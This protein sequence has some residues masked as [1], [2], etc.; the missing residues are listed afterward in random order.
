MVLDQLK[1]A[2][3]YDVLH[4]AFAEAFAFLRRPDLPDLADGRHEIDGDRIYALVISA[5]GRGRENAALEA[6]RRYIDIQY[7]AAGADVIGWR[8]ASLCRESGDGYDDDQDCVLYEDAP[9]AWIDLPAGTFMVFFP[10]DAHAPLACT[11]ACR[12]V[13]VKI[14]VS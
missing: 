5:T 1:N 4:P 12:K 8:A 11:G 6:H 3:L 10:D 9:D 7:T 14:A 2:D 13:V